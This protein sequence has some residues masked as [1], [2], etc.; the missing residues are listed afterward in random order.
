M[1][2]DAEREE[3]PLVWQFLSSLYE[4]FGWFA[5]L[6]FVASFKIVLLCIKSCVPLEA[7]IHFRDLLRCPEVIQIISEP[8]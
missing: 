3:H 8:Y 7:V 5:C 1:K 2:D 4:R 6:F